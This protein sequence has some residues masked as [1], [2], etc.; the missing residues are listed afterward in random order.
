MLFFGAAVVA[1]RSLVEAER[2]GV[3]VYSDRPGQITSIRQRVTRDG[4][5]EKF[6]SAI[7]V[8]ALEIAM[9]GTIGLVSFSFHRRLSK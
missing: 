5:P 2:T 6:E 7:G 9:C 1:G 8:L 4:D 3:A